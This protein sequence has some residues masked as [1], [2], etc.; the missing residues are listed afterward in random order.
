[1][2]VAQQNVCEVKAIGAARRL[3]HLQAQLSRDS[4]RR[5]KAM[6][7]Q[8]CFTKEIEEVGRQLESLGMEV[9]SASDV[10]AVRVEAARLG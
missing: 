3:A 2:V 9:E 4:R 7:A 10:Y 1:M 8:D 6:A 5:E